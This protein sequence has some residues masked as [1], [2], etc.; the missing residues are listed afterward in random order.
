M[1][2]RMVQAV[3]WPNSKARTDL[4]WYLVDPILAACV[5]IRRLAVST[6]C[7]DLEDFFAKRRSA[8]SKIFS[9]VLEGMMAVNG[10]RLLTTGS[11]YL[12]F[13]RSN[14][15]AASLYENCCA[16]ENCV[17]FIDVTEIKIA[18]SKV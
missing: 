5:F 3:E 14:L 10:Q 13:K 16:L 11:S 1:V 4:N 15:Y 2:I 17:G 18:S 8:L 6:R 7:L 12:I 9:E